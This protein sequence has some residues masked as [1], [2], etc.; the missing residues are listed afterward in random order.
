MRI[1]KELLKPLTSWYDSGSEDWY[2]F[3]KAMED[4]YLKVFE[5]GYDTGFLVGAEKGRA[6]GDEND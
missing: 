4:T 3:K 1:D 6:A 5:S 2:E